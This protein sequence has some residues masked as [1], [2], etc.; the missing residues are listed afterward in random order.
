MALVSQLLGGDP[1]LQACLVSDPA[2]ILP[3]AAGEHVS[4]IQTAL[5]VLGLAVDSRELS[6]KRYGP[7]TASAVLNFK[8]QRNIVNRSYQT[9]P[10]N[11]VGK[12]TIAALDAELWRKEA[13]LA[14]PQPPYCGNDP[15]SGPAGVGG[16]AGRRPR[17]LLA[18]A[19]G[20]TEQPSFVPAGGSGDTPS[21]LA[22][23]RIADAKEWVDTTRATLSAVLNFWPGGP[24]SSRDK[25]WRHFGVPDKF[26]LFL[27]DKKIDSLIEFVTGIDDVF[28]KIQERLDPSKS[29]SWIKTA[30]PPWFPESTV[31]A[32]TIDDDRDNRDPPKTAQWQNGTY[33]QPQFIPL[34]SKKKTEVVVHETVHSLGTHEF[35]DVAQP[36]TTDYRQLGSAALIT[37]AW[38][39]STFVLDCKFN[40]SVPLDP[41]E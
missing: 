32:F 23:G 19:V 34:G 26:P 16:A 11:I 3:G 2:H 24:V 33:F 29:N 8:T 4:K 21:T 10:D 37:N 14:T 1:K 15:K 25:I 41:S 30:D 9:K 18:V 27:L 17:L 39:Y 6:T 35:R 7:S 40:K 36:G 22:L 5:Q 38:S 13:S 28:H 31:P 12:M 20:T